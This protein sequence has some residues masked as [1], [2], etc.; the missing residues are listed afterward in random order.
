MTTRPF[1][2]LALAALAVA[3]LT[4]T[5]GLA[6]EPAEQIAAPAPSVFDLP[7]RWDLSIYTLVVFGLLF[8]ILSV[9]A[10]P[11]ILRGMKAREQAMLDAREQALAAQREAEEIRAELQARLAKSH[12]E[13]RAMI[14]EARKDAAKLRADEREVGVQ[15]A[16]AERERATREIAAA[17]D[18]ALQEIYQKSVTLASLMSSKAIR[19]ELSAADHNRLL[20]ESLAELA[21]KAGVN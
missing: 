10:W 9:F 20:D 1:L 11:A 15:E 2:R 19:R 16:Q 18:N 21:G 5:L 4:P 3:L 12:D 8:V 14:E 13:V 7:K 17:R 6:N